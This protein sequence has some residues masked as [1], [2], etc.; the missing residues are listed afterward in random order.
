MQNH[1]FD[2][3]SHIVELRRAIEKGTYFI[4]ATVVAGS[5]IRYMVKQ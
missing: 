5:L 2:E 3:P 1:F 4:P